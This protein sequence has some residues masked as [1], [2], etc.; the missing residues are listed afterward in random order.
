MISCLS[1]YWL[2]NNAANCIPC[3]INCQQ[4]SST[5]KCSVCRAGYYLLSNF[6]CG[7]C[8]NYCKTCVDSISCLNCVNSSL[9]YN[10]SNSQCQSSTISNCY[11]PLNST[12]CQQC[13]STSY[14]TST[15]QCVLIAN[16]SLI[17]NCQQ[18][19]FYSNGTLYCRNCSTGYYNSSG[20]CSFGC[21]IMCNSCFGPHY[22]LCYGCVANSFFSNFHCVPTFNINSGSAFQLL[23]T[24]FNNPSFFV[25]GSML[26]PTGCIP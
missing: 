14:L 5:T 12:A 23:Y 20:F 9:Y 21:S 3:G 18:H 2:D 22:G 19:A 10:S 25:N 6:S 4:C 13:D 11:I 26:L 16:S 24:A 17:V 15:N 7:L 8:A 1:N